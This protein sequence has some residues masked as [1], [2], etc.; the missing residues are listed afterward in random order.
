MPGAEGLLEELE[1]FMDQLAEKPAMLHPPAKV[2][3]TR[4]LWGKKAGIRFGV[5]VDHAVV[6]NK[7][8]DS[9]VR[10]AEET[11]DALNGMRWGSTL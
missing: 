3:G 4:G 6:R 10:D 7:Q 11:F 8:T 1:K 2:P 9:G 5:C